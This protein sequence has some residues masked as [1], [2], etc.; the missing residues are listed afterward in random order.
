MNETVTGQTKKLIAIYAVLIVLTAILA[1]ISR[2]GSRYAV[3]GLLTITPTKAGLIGYYFMHLKNENPIIKGG[4]IFILVN[5]VVFFALTFS[6]I[7][8]R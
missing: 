4:I 2:L 5:L 3:L 8:F 6:D 1:G 7:A